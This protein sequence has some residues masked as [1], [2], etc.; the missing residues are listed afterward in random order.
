MYICTLVQCFWILLRSELGKLGFSRSWIVVVVLLPVWVWGPRQSLVLI[1]SYCKIGR[2]KKEKGI[3]ALVLFVLVVTYFL[4]FLLFR[5]ENSPAQYH[6]GYSKL[7]SWAHSSLDS[8]KVKFSERKLWITFI[9]S[10]SPV[11]WNH[12]LLML[13][14][15]GLKTYY[16]SMFGAKARI[17]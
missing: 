2:G 15:W 6:E 13:E 4:V 11:Q 12:E 14:R 5:L 1:F 7:R 3:K 17:K 9:F 8:Y 16:L 10:V